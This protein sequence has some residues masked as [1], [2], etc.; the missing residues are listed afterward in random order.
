VYKEFFGLQSNPFSVS[1][2][3]RYLFLTRHAHEALACLMHG[4]ENR[5]GFVLLTGEVGTG[6]T[7]LINRLLELLRPQR[8]ATAFIFNP[9]LTVPQF[10]DYMMTDF[11]IPCESKSKSQ[12]LIR[13]CDWLLA[14][15]RAGGNA[16]LI[17]DEAQNLSLELLEEIRMFTNVETSTEKLLQIVL[18]GQP[19]LEQKIK[20]PELRQLRQRVA[21]RARTYPLS[22]AE[23][24][25][26]V[27]QRL[28]IAGS[29]GEQLF[30]P[31][32]LA[33]IYR[34][35]NGIPRVVNLICEQCLVSAFVDRQ[36]V[37]RVSVV[38][39]VARDFDLEENASLPARVFPPPT[40]SADKTTAL[41]APP[42]PNI[43]SDLREAMKTLNDL[44]ERLRNSEP[45]PPKKRS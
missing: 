9:N 34:Y 35:S 27:S 30:D 42:P 23:T 7:T 21:L 41:P 14:R 6:K 28:R 36:K 3:P 13:F 20:Q 45:G 25:L 32:S 16:V 39:A 26:Y 8:V 19:E 1:P 29:N 31:A 15:Y 43:K 2:D 37:V 24:N 33:A 38:D 5:K 40:A 12:N 10:L 44:A 11:G 4:V 18:S 22:P 17:V